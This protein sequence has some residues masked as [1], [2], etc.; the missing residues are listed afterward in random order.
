MTVQSYNV[1]LVKL[2]AEHC[3]VLAEVFDAAAFALADVSEL[4]VNHVLVVGAVVIW[5]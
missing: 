2:V 1:V 5:D 4:E 3:P